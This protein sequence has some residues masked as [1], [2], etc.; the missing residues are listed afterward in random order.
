MSNLTI[1]DSR[2]A[3]GRTLCVSFSIDDV[4]VADAE[5]EIARA[6]LIINAAFDVLGMTVKTE[7]VAVSSSSSTAESV[8]VVKA[9]GLVWETRDDKRYYKVLA[10]QW[11]KHGVRVW[12]ETLPDQLHQSSPSGK[13]NLDGWLTHVVMKDD[14]TPLKVIAMS[15]PAD[16]QRLGGG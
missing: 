13:L 15:S 11:E 14:K 7:P 4:S 16:I 6:A 3:G 8:R 12:D 2:Q 10:G 5:T 9:V 1:S